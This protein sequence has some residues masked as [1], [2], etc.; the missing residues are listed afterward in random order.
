MA[1]NS[2]TPMSDDV[3][4]AIFAALVEMQDRKVPPA[5]SRQLVGEHFRI[6]DQL[7]AEVE[8]EGLDKEWPPLG[9]D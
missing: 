7:V 9:D 5:R 4:K 6:P 2:R 1:D 3:R 8:A